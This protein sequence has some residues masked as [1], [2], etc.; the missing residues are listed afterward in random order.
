M[1]LETCAV[2]MLKR[3]GFADDRQVRRKNLTQ[4]RKGAKK[5]GIGEMFRKAERFSKE[6]T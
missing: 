4:S 3:S 6:R 5:R 1:L 2:G